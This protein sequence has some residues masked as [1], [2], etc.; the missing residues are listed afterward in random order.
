MSGGNQ[1]ESQRI[2]VVGGGAVGGL[3]AARLARAGLAVNVLARGAH[4]EAMRRD[5]LT[6]IEG[7]TTFTARV[8]ATDDP[9]SLGPQDVVFICF[10][11]PALVQ[12]AASLA[13]LIGAHT[14]IVSVMNGVPWWYLYEFGGKHAN[15]RLES[16]DPHGSVSAVLPPAQSSGVV[17]HLSSSV[18]APGV[19]RKGNGNQMIVGA[20]SSHRQPQAAQ[21]AAL[22]AQ[23][24]FEATASDNIRADIWA[25]LWGNMTMNPISALTRSTGDVILNDPLTE[26]LVVTIMEEARLIA[27]ELGIHIAMTAQERNAITRKLGAFKTSMLQDVEGGRALEV[28]ALLGAPFELAQRMDIDVPALGM[29]YG[30]VRQLDAN[31]RAAR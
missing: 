23:A 19:I 24:G 18:V 6:L 21:V 8:R 31:L 4:L 25:K 26:R 10:K 27:R 29:L 11:G 20:A 5:G 12:S 22:F 30:M 13:P 14:H 16:V 2:T 28:E 3:V 15:G 7:E 1:L 17:V 9:A